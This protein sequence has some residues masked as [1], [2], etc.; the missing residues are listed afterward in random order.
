MHALFILL[1]TLVSLHTTALAQDT[2]T[3]SEA[4]DAPSADAPATET[5]ETDDAPVESTLPVS[6]A[7]DV[8]A[9]AMDAAATTSDTEAAQTE[10]MALTKR[11]LK[12]QR[13]TN[14]VLERKGLNFDATLSREQQIQNAFLARRTGTGMVTTGAVLV[15]VGFVVPAVWIGA[16]NNCS[17]GLCLLAGL[18]LGGAIALPVTVVAIGGGFAIIGA[19]SGIGLRGRMQL[20]EL[21]ID[22]SARKKDVLTMHISPILS[23]TQNGVRLAFTF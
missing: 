12:V 11:Q 13:R 23:P 19:G 16:I 3:E 22:P 17:D 8:D 10:E 14:R 9:L 21:G 18:F 6:D 7:P 5:P 2:S 15:G 20:K 1:F 4:V